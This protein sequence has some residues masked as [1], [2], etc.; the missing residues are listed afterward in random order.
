[1]GFGRLLLNGVTT[2]SLVKHFYSWY[3]DFYTSQS[4]VSQTRKE[5]KIAN[6]IVRSQEGPFTLASLASDFWLWETLQCLWVTSSF[7]ELQVS[8]LALYI[9]LGERIHDNNN[10]NC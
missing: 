6:V 3:P 4:L 1:M 5:E 7:I 10:D 2:K 9:L 8:L